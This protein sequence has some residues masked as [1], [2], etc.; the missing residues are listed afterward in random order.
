MK[1]STTLQIGARSSFVYGCVCACA[2]KVY[3]AS[4]LFRGSGFVVYETG[5]SLWWLWMVVLQSDCGGGLLSS[6]AVKGETTRIFELVIRL[7]GTGGVYTVMISFAALN[8]E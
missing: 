2:L 8:K 6:Q 1:L 5:R 3:W 4:L 7:L